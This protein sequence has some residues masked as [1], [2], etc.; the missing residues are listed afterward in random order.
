[1]NAATTSN[2]LFYQMNFVLTA[3]RQL[4][5]NDLIGPTQFGFV[6]NSSTVDHLLEMYHRILSTMD[7]QML[8]KGVFLDVSK[9]FD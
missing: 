9:A 3:S 1:M 2:V 8:M 4:T 5:D 7:L 6:R